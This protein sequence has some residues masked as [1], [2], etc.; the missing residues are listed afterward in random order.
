MEAV[1]LQG[2]RRH[3][4]KGLHVQNAADKPC[5]VHLHD[6]A[7]DAAQGEAA[8]DALVQ[9]HLTEKPCGG[10][11]GPAGA[12]LHGEAVVEVPRGVNDLSGGLGDKQ[13]LGVLGVPG[14]TGHDALGVADVV[15]DYDVVHVVLRDGP[16]GVGVADQVVGED[17]HL[18][19]KFGVGACVAH[20]AA[21]DGVVLVPAVAVGVSVGVAGGGPQ[22][23]HVDVELPAADGGGPA[24]VLRGCG[25]AG[26]V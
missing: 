2:I 9:H 8:V 24:A 18:V 11:G 22:E 26:P 21:G 16:G 1:V 25:R 23:G 20:G 17:Y 19:G 13:L 12:H 14:G 4:V 7:G 15:G 5:L 6:L 10:Q 3:Q